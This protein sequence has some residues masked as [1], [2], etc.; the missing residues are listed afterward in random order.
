MAEPPSLAPPQIVKWATV[1]L[2][3]KTTKTRTAPLPL[4]VTLWPLPFSVV[5]APMVIGAGQRDRAV[6]GEGDSAAQG[7]GVAQSRLRVGHHD[8]TS[9]DLQQRR[10]TGDRAVKIADDRACKLLPA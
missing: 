10:G 6:A 9:K 4:I 7:H 2:T 3:L 5:S 1:K 8:A